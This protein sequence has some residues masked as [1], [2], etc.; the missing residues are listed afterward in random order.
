MRLLVL[1]G[2]ADGL[3]VWFIRGEVELHAGVEASIS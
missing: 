1:H 3:V 2:F